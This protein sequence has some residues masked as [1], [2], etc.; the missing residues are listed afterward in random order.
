MSDSETLQLRREGGWLHVTFQRPEKRN[1][2]SLAMVNA[3]IA[4]FAGAEKDPGVRG[5]VLRGAGGHFCSG[6]DIA[7]MQ[8]AASAASDDGSDAIAA[9][10]RRF[11]TMLQV[12]DGLGAAV[13][14]VCPVPRCSAPRVESPASLR[15]NS[16]ARRSARRCAAATLLPLPENEPSA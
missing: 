5:V 2:M 8:R 4:A 3:M 6:G 11:G 13:V 14:A 12:L 16:L 1:A 15:P 7:D 10:N 9:L